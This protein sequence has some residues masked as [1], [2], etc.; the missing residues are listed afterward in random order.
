M[1]GNTTAQPRRPGRPRDAAKHDAILDAARAL[2]FARGV[3]AVPIEAVAAEAG[4]SKV[5]VYGHFGDKLTLFEAVVAREVATM[6]AALTTPDTEDR[7]IEERLVAFGT[8]LMRF[9]TTPEVENFDRLLGQ[10]AQRRPDLARRFFDAGPGRCRA[11]LAGLIA[12]AA[13][14]GELAPDDPTAA[15]EDLLALWQGMLPIM[16][17]LHLQA[18]PDQPDIAARVRRGVRLFMRAHAP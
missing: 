17:R 10:E 4:V 5:T 6:H 8:S 15:A 1:T 3:E 12:E 14:R 7:A 11:F 18:S 9:L 16:C 2:F 13:A